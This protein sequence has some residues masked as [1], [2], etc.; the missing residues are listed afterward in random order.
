MRLLAARLI[1]CWFFR[2]LQDKSCLMRA[3]L[4]AYLHRPGVC[5][6]DPRM[7]VEPENTEEE[8]RSELYAALVELAFAPPVDKP[9]LADR[10]RAACS[11]LHA[12]IVS[13][14]AN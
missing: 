6:C 9:R 13:G 2:R 10:L 11:K 4:V 3:I 1:F 12:L 5:S 7:P 14:H 8:L